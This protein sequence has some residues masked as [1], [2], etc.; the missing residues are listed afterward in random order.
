MSDERR[1]SPR[2]PV[3]VPASV[4]IAGRSHPGRIR[5]LCRDA[6]FVEIPGFWSIGTRVSLSAEL[7]GGEGPVDLAGRIV[8]QAAP[9]EGVSGVAVLFD[10]LPPATATRIDFFL[11]EQEPPEA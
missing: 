1:K 11:A 10:D 9:E 2:Y 5:D 7:P 3:D 8:R 6:L 4:E